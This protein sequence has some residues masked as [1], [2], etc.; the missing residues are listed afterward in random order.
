MENFQQVSRE[1]DI[2]KLIKAAFDADFEVDGAWGYSEE[3]ATIIKNSPEKKEFQHTLTSMRAYL[4]MSMTL[5]ENERYGSIN[6][7]EISRESTNNIDIVNYQI[8]AMKEKVYA[9]FINEYKAG[10]GTKEFD[11]NEHFKKRKEATLIREVQ[12]YFKLI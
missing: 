4:E 12:H 5:D 9:D 6:I 3:D 1:E 2:K 8:S 11:M 7:T 10:Y